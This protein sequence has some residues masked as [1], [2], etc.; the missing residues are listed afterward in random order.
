MDP[1]RETSWQKG[2]WSLIVTQF[3]GAFSDNAFKFMLIFMFTASS[4]ALQERDRLVFVVA[5]LFSI[6]FILF[7][8]PGGYVADCAHQCEI[9]TVVTSRAFLEKVNLAVP[10][11]K[12][13]LEDLAAGAGWGERLLALG[14]AW[15]LPARLLEKALGAESAATLDD[16]ATVI[17]SSGSTGNPKGGHADALQH[18]LQCGTTRAGMFEGLTE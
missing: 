13:L 6:P 8:L 3:Q 11:E 2:F 16:L 17:F 9:R 5:A 15:V 12:I 4:L 1:A 18:R 14:L 10:G 7:S